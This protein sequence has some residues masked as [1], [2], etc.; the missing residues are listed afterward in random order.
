MNKSIE[1]TIIDVRLAELHVKPLADWSNEEWVFFATN[2]DR[3]VE[4]VKSG[5]L[6]EFLPH[7]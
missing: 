5:Y 7:K 3:V 6:D 2:K 4:L 1:Q